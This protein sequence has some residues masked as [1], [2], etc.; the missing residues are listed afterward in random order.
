LKARLTFVDSGDS[1]ANEDVAQNHQIRGQLGVPSK[2]TRLVR[3]HDPDCGVNQNIDHDSECVK[4]CI[5]CV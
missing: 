2:Q 1:E 3:L 5:L 4:H